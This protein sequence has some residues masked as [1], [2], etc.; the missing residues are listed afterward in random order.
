MKRRT[1]KYSASIALNPAAMLRPRFAARSRPAR[2]TM[3]LLRAWEPGELRRGPLVRCWCRRGDSNSHGLRPL[4]PQASVSTNF[5]TSACGNRIR[6]RPT[7]AMRPAHFTSERRSL[8]RRPARVPASAARSAGAFVRAGSRRR[9]GV[10]HAAAP[11]FGLTFAR[12]ARP[13]LERKNTAARI[14]VVRDRKF[15]E[16]VAPKRLPEAPSRTPRPCRRP[17][18]AGAARAR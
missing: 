11:L 12:Y 15:A 8:S 9:A 16:P 4:A 14:A 13:R 17:C 2:T 10:H 5:T 18:R 6:A 1:G 7:I 3:T